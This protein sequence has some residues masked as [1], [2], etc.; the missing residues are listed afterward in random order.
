MTKEAEERK[1]HE[2]K[3]QEVAKAQEE[4]ETLSMSRKAREQQVRPRPTENGVVVSVR[5][6]DLGVLTQSFPS[7]GTMSAVYDWIGSLSLT[8]KYFRL[9]R[10]PNFT[11]YADESV[12][13]ADRAPFNVGRTFSVTTSDRQE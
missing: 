10:M 11:L 7:S 4:A 1:Q 5:H 6:V 13:V 12:S 8:P 2:L 9:T 3:E